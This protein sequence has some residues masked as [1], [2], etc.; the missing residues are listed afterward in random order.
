MIKWEQ[1]FILNRKP[2]IN[3][4]GNFIVRP[5]SEGL[6]LFFNK[7]YKDMSP[8]LPGEIKFERGN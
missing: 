2:Y 5:N 3:E 1:P 7:K 4:K 8:Y 6:R